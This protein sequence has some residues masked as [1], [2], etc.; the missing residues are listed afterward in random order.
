MAGAI[1]SDQRAE[2]LVTAARA[3]GRAGRVDDAASLAERAVEQG[4]SVGYE[5]LVQLVVQD[6]LGLL[7]QP[8]AR[9]ATV[10]ELRQQIRHEDRARYY[11][12]SR[13]PGEVAAAVRSAQWRKLHRTVSDAVQLAGRTIG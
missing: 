4:S 1:A 12:A 13:S 2:V 6:R 8:A 9:L 10:K 7:R 3:F 5:V 11:G